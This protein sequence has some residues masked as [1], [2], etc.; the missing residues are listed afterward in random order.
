[1]SKIKIFDTIEGYEAAALRAGMTINALNALLG[2]PTAWTL[3]WSEPFGGCLEYGDFKFDI[4]ISGEK[5]IV[6]RVGITMWQLGA[7]NEDDSEPFP[8]PKEKVRLGGRYRP[9]LQ[10]LNPGAS[11]EAIE[12]VL[13]ARNVTYHA[14]DGMD[15]T[16]VVKRIAI[17]DTTE[18]GFCAGENGPWL[19]YV[20]VLSEIHPT[21]PIK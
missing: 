11:F 20:D 14:L 3:P 19:M 6:T 15:A 12:D 7:L 13:K 16:E 18:L 4:E 10:G 9:D 1:M 17:G 2:L 8:L 21:Y 5:I